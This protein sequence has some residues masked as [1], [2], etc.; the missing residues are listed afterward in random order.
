MA[1]V[2]KSCDYPVAV[3]LQV[4]EMLNPRVKAKWDRFSN[5]KVIVTDVEP[6]DLTY[7]EG[8]YYAKGC[9]RNKHTSTTGIY[10]EIP[11]EKSDGSSWREDAIYSTLE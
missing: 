10:S 1:L 5:L 7:P 3:A 6:K 9:F 2:V 11:M 4:F 8:W